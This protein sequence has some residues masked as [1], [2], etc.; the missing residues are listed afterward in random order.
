MKEK[1]LFSH[2]QHNWFPIYLVDLS[3]K[4]AGVNFQKVENREFN[5]SERLSL[6]LQLMLDSYINKLGDLK[7]FTFIAFF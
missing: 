1:H 4:S 2:V 3:S 5:F 7:K 6:V